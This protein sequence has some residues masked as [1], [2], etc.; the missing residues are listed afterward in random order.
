MFTYDPE[1]KRQSAQWK[2]GT[3]PRPKKAR[4][5]RS[6]KKVMVIFFESQGLIRVEWVPQGLTFT[7]MRN[8]P[9]SSEKV[10]REDEKEEAI[11]VD[12]WS[13]VV[14]SG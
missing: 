1:S 2:H 9:N 5:C 12:K 7:S 4:M 3:S 13:V 10:Q 14:P 11:A 6:Q 8:F